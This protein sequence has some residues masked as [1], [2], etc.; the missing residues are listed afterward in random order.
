MQIY[1]QH[2]IATTFFTFFCFIHD[3]KLYLRTVKT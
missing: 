3:K 1:I 2:T